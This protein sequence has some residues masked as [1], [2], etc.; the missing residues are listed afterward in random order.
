MLASRRIAAAGLTALLVTGC[1][2]VFPERERRR[3]DCHGVSVTVS[4]RQRVP[5]WFGGEEYVYATA[6]GHGGARIR[7]QIDNNGR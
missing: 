3:F 2:L 5:G 1:A 6:V 7:T 4:T